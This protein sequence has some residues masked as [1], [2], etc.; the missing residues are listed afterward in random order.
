MAGREDISAAAQR[1][2]LGRRDGTRPPYPA[3]LT[4]RIDNFTSGPSTPV[5]TPAPPRVSVRER[6]REREREKKKLNI[7]TV[8]R[9]KHTRSWTH[10]DRGEDRDT[11]RLRQTE[12]QM[13]RWIYLYLA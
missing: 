6:E 12:I 13:D 11:R 4:L 8:K 5:Y 2:H 7:F 3:D 1:R 9:N 10:T